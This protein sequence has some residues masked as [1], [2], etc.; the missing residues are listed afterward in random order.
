MAVGLKK[1]LHVFCGLWSVGII[2]ALSLSLSLSLVTLYNFNKINS[3]LYVCPPAA[4][5]AFVFFNPP[6]EGRPVPL[7]SGASF[8]AHTET[9]RVK[10]EGWP[11]RLPPA[12][13]KRVTA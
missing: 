1:L 9:I 11:G 7:G 6:R 12:G 2:I 5:G 4:A 10:A 13:P 8:F 3:A